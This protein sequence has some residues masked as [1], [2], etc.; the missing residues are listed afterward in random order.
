MQPLLKLEAVE[1]HFLR[2]SF[3]G[4]QKI[5]RAVDGVSLEVRKGETLG[6]VG[7]SGCGKSTLANLIIRLE[8]ATAGKIELD[9]LDIAHIPD[10]K[11]RAIRSRIQIIF[12]DP[13]SSLDPRLTVRKLWLSQCK[14][15]ENGATRK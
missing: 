5:I 10:S 7:E 2:K 9:G 8:E 15:R 6:I 14:Y 4:S 3:L 11:L 1:K 12:Q 13:Y